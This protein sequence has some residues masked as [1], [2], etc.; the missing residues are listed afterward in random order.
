MDEVE[1][2]SRLVGD[3]YDASLDPALWPEVLKTTCEYIE[4]ATG[5]L[6]S[7]ETAPGNAHFY[8][9]WGNDEKFLQSYQDLYVKLNPVL[10]PTLLL[11]KAGDVLSTIDLMPLDEFFASRFYKEWVAPQ[12]L[13]DS[14]FITL[15]K[16][17]TSYAFVAVTRHERHGLVD[18]ESRRRMRLLA[19]HFVRAITIGKVI[20]LHKAEA[21]ALSDTL[22]GLAASTFIVDASGRIS[23]ANAAAD[24]MLSEGAIVQAL[25]G[26]LAATDPIADRRLHDVFTSASHG[27]EAVGTKGIAIPLATRDAEHYVAHV[28]PLTSGVRRRAGVAYSA[29]AAVF[30]RKA[31]LEAPHP[32]EAM[33]Q[34]YQLTPAEMR[35]L[36]MIV[37]VGGV[38]EIAPVLGISEATVKTHLQHIFDKTA[39]KRQA[40]LVKLVAGYVSPLGR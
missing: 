36:M 8:F 18:D 9:Q 15:D 2:V 35:V 23:H 29:V 34:A 16:T 19:P 1:Q 26:K 25:A 33:A 5:T 22:D 21:S 27:D 40:D 13:V 12:G 17:A 14:V 30:V 37:E 38:R 6:M 28:L 10:V 7:Q 20:Q 31:A 4:G 24:A 32:L 39:T 11:A 3:I